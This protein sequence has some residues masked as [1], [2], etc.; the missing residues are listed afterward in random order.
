MTLLVRMLGKVNRCVTGVSKPHWFW[1][2][3]GYRMA[4]SQRSV[5]GRLPTKQFNNSKDEGEHQLYLVP[6]TRECT[7]HRRAFSSKKLVPSL[8]RITDSVLAPWTS[9]PQGA[10]LLGDC[11][12]HFCTVRKAKENLHLVGRGACFEWG[13]LTRARAIL[14]SVG[15]SSTNVSFYIVL[16]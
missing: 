12:V 15:R 16:S 9:D 1:L 4:S 11:F 13:T 2:S 8:T 10:W 5:S 6:A 7:S 14:L 3:G